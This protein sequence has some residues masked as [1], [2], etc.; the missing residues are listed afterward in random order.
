MTALL[1]VAKMDLNW[2]DDQYW[3]TLFDVLRE[4]TKIIT[5]KEKRPVTAGDMTKFIRKDR[6]G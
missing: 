5:P 6:D 1:G 4:Y 3:S 2:A